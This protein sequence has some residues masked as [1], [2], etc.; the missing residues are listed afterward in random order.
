LDPLARIQKG[1]EGFKF[2]FDFLKK[3]VIAN[4][5]LGLQRADGSLVEDQ[6]NIRGMF[7]DHFHN[8]FSPYPLSH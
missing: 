8:C 5:V 6:K 1:D 7:G 3:K 2:F 4:R